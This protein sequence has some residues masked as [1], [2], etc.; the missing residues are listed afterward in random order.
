MMSIMTR[1]DSL[2]TMDI[3]RKFLH[4]EPQF[5]SSALAMEHVLQRWLNIRLPVT[6]QVPQILRLN[7]VEDLFCQSE[8][9]TILSTL[10]LFKN[11]WCALQAW[12]KPSQ[13]R[14]YRR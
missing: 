12:R 6:P 1:S 5:L 9:V 10:A 8:G 14:T 7:L 13:R 2:R 11:R 4:T 3:T